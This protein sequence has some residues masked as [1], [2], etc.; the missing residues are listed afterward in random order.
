MKYVPR[1]YFIY[2]KDARSCHHP[3]ICGCRVSVRCMVS[4]TCLFGLMFFSLE[5]SLSRMAS[6]SHTR[7]WS[8]TGAHVQGRLKGKIKHLMS[9][10]N[11]QQQQLCFY[12]YHLT[13]TESPHLLSSE[14]DLTRSRSA[15][16]P[17]MVDFVRSN[18]CT[19]VVSR[20][21]LV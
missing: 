10:L 1:T 4:W 3:W 15:Q 18:C 7:S 12:T 16:A 6:Q 20:R 17:H 2:L 19:H 8:V 11:E 21:L 14:S 5:L 9:E 13:C